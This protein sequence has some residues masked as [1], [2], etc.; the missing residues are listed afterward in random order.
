MWKACVL[1]WLWTTMDMGLMDDDEEWWECD[2]IEHAMVWTA[3]NGS[4]VTTNWLREK[5]IVGVFGDEREI[6]L[7]QDSRWDG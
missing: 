2:S 6:P 7:T 1:E 5:H 4:A 3:G